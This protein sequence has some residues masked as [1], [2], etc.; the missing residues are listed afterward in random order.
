MDREL[1]VDEVDENLICGI[2]RSVFKDPVSRCIK[3]HVYC[4]ACIAQWAG[5]V[6]ARC[7]IGKCALLRTDQEQLVLR[8]L[9]HNLVVRCPSVLEAA[10]LPQDQK[11]LVADAKLPPASASSSSSSN[12]PCAPLPAP[13]PAPA[14]TSS[15]QAK[16]GQKRKAME[17]E[18]TCTWKGKLEHLSSHEDK[19]PYVIVPCT[20][21]CSR[22][23]RRMHMGEH[24]DQ[25]PLRDVQCHV[26]GSSILQYRL[27]DHL[28]R[29][30][31][32][33]R[34]RCP[35]AGCAAMVQR[36]SIA[37]HRRDCPWEVVA[38]AFQRHGCNAQI[39]RKDDAKHQADEATAHANLLA[40]KMSEVEGKLARLSEKL[41]FYKAGVDTLAALQDQGRRATFQWV[42]QDAEEWLESGEARYSSLFVLGYGPPG[43]AV[44][45]QLRMTCS[46][47]VES[48][49]IHILHAGGSRW[50]P[51]SFE[52]TSFEVIKGSQRHGPT[53]PD[54]MEL[55]QLDNAGIGVASFMTYEVAEEFM[56]AGCL[57]IVCHVC[58][59]LNSGVHTLNTMQPDEAAA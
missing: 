11:D 45:L 38:C 20:N 30:C 15:G 39:L 23:V 40:S 27:K 48:I 1:F 33:A 21:G 17:R 59:D 22:R 42:I 19:C 29:D 13:S 46:P 10:E 52:G 51:I 25:C 35:N 6:R 43:G 36:H 18:S 31:P 3:G 2:C 12:E 50:L 58:V 9:L 47:D 14:P 5:N 34:V 7:P 4:R 44:R 24:M 8:N 49:D 56:E 41:E 28:E 55:K 53:P 37:Q 32:H 54:S 16:V 57:T 26:C